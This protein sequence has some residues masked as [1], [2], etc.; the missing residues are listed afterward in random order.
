MNIKTKKLEVRILLFYVDTN[1]IIRVDLSIINIDS[2]YPFPLLPFLNDYFNSFEL[3]N[4]FYF[5]CVY[6]DKYKAMSCSTNQL[7]ATF[8]LTHQCN[9]RCDYCYTG[10]KLNIPMTKETADLAIDFVLTESRNNGIEKLLITFFGGEP[11]IE[12]E[13]LFHIADRFINEKDNF[14]VNFQM[15]TNGT[16]LNESLLNELFERKIFISLSIDGAPEIQDRQRKNAAGKGTSKLVAK[17][18][19]MLLHKNPATNVTCVIT[20]DSADAVA[21]SVDWIYNQGFRYITT[22]LDY[23]GDW[24]LEN[25][26][27]LRRSY[28]KLADW[29]QDKMMVQER[30]Y[31]SAFDERIKSRTMNPLLPNERCL[32]GYKQ[33]SIAPDGE[34]YPCIT[35]VTTEKIPE[36]MIGHVQEGFD[37][38]CRDYISRSSEKEKSE[39]VGCAVKDRCSSSVSYTHL[40]LPTNR[41]V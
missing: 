17:A 11:L 24:N 16:L 22:T 3:H 1:T 5:F 18:A 27:N 10:E 37:E 40:T 31:L 12:K 2:I 29:Y 39:C 6:K 9:L 34:L 41:E 21:E 23:T 32:I 13:L 7:A 25:M 20:P 15:S 26:E 14:Q 30:F 19:K 33:F 4:F 36:F 28:T 8:H 35:F 38:N